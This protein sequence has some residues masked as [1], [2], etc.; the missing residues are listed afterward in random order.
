MKTRLTR[1]KINV[2]DAK[3]SDHHPVIHDGVLFWNVMMQGKKR[4][5]KTGDSY[6]NG[7]GKVETDEQYMQRLVRVAHVIIGIIARHPSIDAIALCEGPIQPAHVNL[8]LQILKQFNV[9]KRFFIDSMMNNKFHK[10][11]VDGFQHWGLLMLADKKYQ[12]NAIQCE[13]IN[14]SILSGKLTNRF[15]IWKLSKDNKNKYLAL[16]HF[17]FGGDE[18]VVEKNKLSAHGNIYC[19][20]VNDIFKKYASDNLI[21]CADF[22]FNPYLINE[23]KDRVL[24][25]I[26]NNNS[27]LLTSESTIK[28]VTVDGILLSL[29]EKQKYYSSRLSPG[30][31]SRLA[32][33]HSLMST[34]I[35][36]KHFSF[37]SKTQSTLQ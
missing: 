16:A 17:P 8:F 36:A 5:G 13:H 25:N 3:I 2:V 31:F 33:E 23:W 29:Q 7:F 28:K 19:E 12:V 9:M 4:Q 11:D 35:I 26:K 22:N 32:S 1:Q 18:H 21:L 10:P 27:I 37:Q 30:L 34:G 15:Q 24:D 6:N 20:L 14:D